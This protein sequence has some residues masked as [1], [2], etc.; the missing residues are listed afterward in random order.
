MSVIGT[1][2]WVTRASK[3]FKVR[4]IRWFVKEF[5]VK[6]IIVKCRAGN[7]VD[8]IGCYDK[9]MIPKH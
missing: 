5:I 2:E 6:R 4:I 9:G 8:E 7:S 1:Q 3:D